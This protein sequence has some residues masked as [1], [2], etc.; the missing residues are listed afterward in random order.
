M[1]LG[2]SA[3]ALGCGGGGGG[4]GDDSGATPGPPCIF[5]QQIDFPTGAVPPGFDI[6]TL[7]QVLDNS[8][9]VPIPASV[10]VNG[11]ALSY[12][13]ANE[14]YEGNVVVA[15]GGTIKLSVTVDGATYAASAVQFASYPTISAPT[16]GVKWALAAS[17][18]V[19]WSGGASTPTALYGIGVLDA[20]DPNGNL[21]WPASGFVELA[22]L[23][24]S[25]V[26]IGPGQL[27]AGNRLVI[28]GLLDQADI[29]GTAMGSGFVFGG[30]NYVP[31]AVTTTV[32]SPAAT[33]ESISVAPGSA[34]IAAGKTQQFTATGF[35]SDFSVVDV[36]GSVTWASLDPGKATV[37]GMGLAT[38]TGA[39]SAT[40][41]ATSG[42][43]SGSVS[44]TVVPGFAAGA[45]Y[46]NPDVFPLADTVIGDLNGDGRN[47]VAVIENSLGS[48]I[49]VYYQNSQGKLDPP[50]LITTD[51]AISGIAVGDVNNDGW[52]DLVVSGN[53]T[54]ATSGLLGRIAVF[55]QDSVAHTLGAPQELVPSTNNVGP[56]AI[57][58]LNHDALPDIVS[59]GSG[60]GVNGVVSIFFQ[61]PSGTLGPEVTYTSVPVAFSVGYGEI[62]VADMNNDGMNDIVLQSGQLQLAVIKQVSAGVFSG[63]PDFYNVTT[64]YWPYF[65]S[66]RLG[67]L[68]G[69]GLI[70]VVTSDPGN[71]GYLNMFLQNG[72]GTL[73]GPTLKTA[74]FLGQSEVDMADLDGDG[75]NDLIVLGDGNTVQILYQ[76]ADHSFANSLTYTLPT[77]STGGTTVHQALSVGDV[78]GD[79][80]AD[81]VASWWADESVYVVPRLP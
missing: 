18:V 19:G 63:T 16:A 64:S 36:T 76:G 51:L 37:D 32:H 61:G 50:Q 33:L 23:G 52:T 24:A 41:T 12:V 31:I 1:S 10:T 15:P 25:N 46:G 73:T 65:S 4:E 48:R 45:G 20:A 27:S 13:A 62:H 44:M 53:S 11:V 71:S 70:D 54:T 3:L 69:D 38:G 2:L 80:L 26:A 59:A 39:G 56:V 78:T 60:S 21:V 49:L 43:I 17:N 77:F 22:S 14:D 79:G 28:V 40:I 34:F 6:G 75:L 7:V 35:Y 5:A 68:N 55:R 29:P 67:D 42:S 66:F 47:D 30:F 9:S 57:A 74:T 72:S 58:D 81:I 8:C